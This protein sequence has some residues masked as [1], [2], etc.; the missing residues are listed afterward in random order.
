[1]RI[2]DSRQL[3]G[4]IFPL[5]HSG[6]ARKGWE[7]G[8]RASILCYRIR[9]RLTGPEDV[10]T[11]LHEDGS[12]GD[13][14][15]GLEWK[16]ASRDSR[17]MSA[18]SFVFPS[19]LMLGSS[20]KATPTQGAGG[21]PPVKKAGDARAIPIGEG[22]LPDSRFAPKAVNIPFVVGKADDDPRA[23]AKAPPPGQP[24]QN[25]LFLGIGAQVWP[26]SGGGARAGATFQP[27][28]QSAS[29][30]RFANP[31]IGGARIRP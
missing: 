29:N 31:L 19:M 14:I 12:V 21:G 3:G 7:L 1:M 27:P 18:W 9:D 20:S 25:V 8:T 26:L 2:F 22:G 17:V 23:A 16:A 24:N 6:Y 13:L 30:T 28:R 4:G 5:Q 10:G 11:W 15:G